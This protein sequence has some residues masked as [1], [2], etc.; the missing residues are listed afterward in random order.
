MELRMF[1]YVDSLDLHITGATEVS[2]D[3]TYINKQ[4]TDFI[5][6]TAKTNS[7]KYFSFRLGYRKHTIIAFWGVISTREA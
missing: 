3:T 1:L 6:S 7:N 4:R 5:L 2:V